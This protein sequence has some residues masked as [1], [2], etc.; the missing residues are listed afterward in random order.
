MFVAGSVR[1]TVQRQPFQFSTHVVVVVI[2]CGLFSFIVRCFVLL[3][4]ALLYGAAV[5]SADD[6]SKTFFEFNRNGLLN[7]EYLRARHED[8][9]IPEQIPSAEAVKPA[10]W[11]DEMDGVWEVESA[12]A[13]VQCL[14]NTHTH[15]HTNYDISATESR[16]SRVQRSLGGDVWLVHR[17]EEVWSDVGR[18]R[19]Q[20]SARVTPVRHSVARVVVC[21]A[22][23]ARQRR[24]RHRSLSTLQS[25]RF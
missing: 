8:T 13:N 15:T 6:P 21:A 5:A 10:E 19:S 7:F 25:R 9:D 2:L 16:E 11:D 22:R 18:R 17:H 24:R 1:V 4:F 14:Q 23:H 3:C 12:R 20:L